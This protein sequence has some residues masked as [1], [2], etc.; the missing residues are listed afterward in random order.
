MSS[1]FYLELYNS[2]VNSDMVF[3]HTPE[4]FV[5]NQT[6]N[7]YTTAQNKLLTDF[8]NRL[9]QYFD[10][11]YIVTADMDGILRYE[12]IF[13][14]KFN[15]E[16]DSREFRKARLFNKLAITS[17]FTYT[18]ILQM[19]HNLFGEGNYGFSVDYNEM[20]IHVDINTDIPQLFNQTIEDI[21]QMIPANMMMTPSYIEPFTLR[22][23]NVNYTNEELGQFT[24]G[25]LSQ[26]S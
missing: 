14:I 11:N 12:N 25:E 19:L 2:E 9:K 15:V 13:D 4:R 20:E 6:V 8:D 7:A 24:N 5:N 22:Y 10:N 23:L 1:W 18:F 26:Y 16:S 3:R 21:R 17:P